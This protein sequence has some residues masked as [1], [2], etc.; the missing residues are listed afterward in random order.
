MNITI[1]TVPRIKEGE[2]TNETDSSKVNVNVTVV[3]GLSLHPKYKGNVTNG[4]KSV[5][6]KKT[7]WY[8]LETNID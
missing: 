1:A 4:T 6:S 7:C 8:I 3:M 2:S 5:T